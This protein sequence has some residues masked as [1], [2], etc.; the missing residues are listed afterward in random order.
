V[1]QYNYL[2]TIAYEGTNFSGWQVQPNAVTIQSIIE[3]KLFLIFSQPIFIH[4]SGR[5]DAGVH[6]H[7]QRAHFFCSKKLESWKILKSLNGLLP[8]QIR[9]LNVEEVALDFHARF[10]AIGKEYHYRIFWGEAVLPFE[11]KY[12]FHHRGLFDLELLNLGIKEFIGTHDFTSFTNVGGAA[13]NF[14]R[15]IDSIEILEEENKICC[16]RFKGN[17]FLYKMVR[18]IVGT[19]LEVAKGSLPASDIPKILALKDRKA[20]GKAASAQGLTLYKVFYPTKV[21]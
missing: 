4:A 10:S 14:V 19:L 20:A 13:K 1:S 12:V 3:E 5:T 6:A 18:N 15:T 17:G 9:V 11:R 2:L 21:S 8:P 7:G 16:L